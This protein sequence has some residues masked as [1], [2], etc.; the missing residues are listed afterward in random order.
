MAL[1][2]SFE[3]SG[4]ILFKYRG[5]IPVLLFLLA[6]PL[7]FGSNRIFYF[8]I[9]MGQWKVLRIVT[10]VL[11]IAITLCGLL[12]RAYTVSTTPKGTS[13]RNTSGQVAKTLNTKGIYSIVRHPL[14]LAN[15]LI[16]AGVLVFTMNIY[17]FL[18]VSLAYWIYYERIMFAEEGFLRQQF[19][20][21][22]EEWA[23]RVPAFIPKFSLFRKGDM[24]FSFKTFLRREYATIYSTVFSYTVADYLMFIL[25]VVVNTPFRIPFEKWLRPSLYILLAF[26]IITLIIKLIKHKT[27]WLKSDSQRD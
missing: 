8:Q 5:Q 13:G 26:T 20:D 24:Q 17:V 15:Y 25:I 27:S 11:A 14:Y 16:W 22:F 21:E 18:I 6:I 4:N 23:A 1:K 3:R 7:L 19:G 2:D 10:I 9:F 12:L